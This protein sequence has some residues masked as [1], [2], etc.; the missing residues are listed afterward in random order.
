MP[1]IWMA[2]LEKYG[3]IVGCKPI[4][5]VLEAFHHFSQDNIND[6]E[7]FM[8]PRERYETLNIPEDKIR[9]FYLSTKKDEKHKRIGVIAMGFQNGHVHI[10]GSVCSNLDKFNSK[11]GKAI[12]MNRL[13]STNPST[14]KIVLEVFK[15]VPKLEDVIKKLSLHNDKDNNSLDNVPFSEYQEL[16][17]KLLT[18]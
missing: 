16:F 3:Q 17:E 15:P 9:L 12:A 18:R 13:R 7:R 5:V 4:H 14:R 2:F 8:K 6:C 10:G 11:T 1:T